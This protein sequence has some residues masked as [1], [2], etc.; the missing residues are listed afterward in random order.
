MAGDGRSRRTRVQND[1]LTRPDHLYSRGGNAEL[2][3]AKET[4]FFMQGAIV[5][6]ART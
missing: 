5:E 1:D 3:L 4:L 6:S 2:F